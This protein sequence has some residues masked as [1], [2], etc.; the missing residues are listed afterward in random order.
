MSDFGRRLREARERRGIPL[1]Q[2]AWATKV[3]L[4]A[5]EALERNDPS[6]LPGGI[7]AR[8]AV[9]AYAREVGL[10]PAATLREF[11]AR[12]DA[13]IESRIIEAEIA[14]SRIEAHPPRDAGGLL[15]KALVLGL[16]IA[17]IIMYLA[18]A[19]RADTQSIGQPPP[20]PSHR[21]S[22][23]IG[24]TLPT[25]VKLPTLMQRW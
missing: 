2:I 6:R 5:L 20:D 8:A 3:S 11:R 22:R 15:L 7:F 23:R 4:P 1:A 13:D 17:A 18:L 21:T 14:A 16:A 25:P 19:R 24:L 12:F 10:D 9:K